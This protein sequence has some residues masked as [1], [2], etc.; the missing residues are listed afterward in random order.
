VTD[1]PADRRLLIIFNPAAGLRRRQR[2]EAVLQRLRAR[3]CAATVCETTGPGDA[4]RFAAAADPTRYDLLVVA[5]GDGTVNEAINGLGDAPLPLAILPLGTANVLAAE[6]GLATDPDSIAAAIAQGAPRPIALG[7][8][9]GRRFILMAGAGFDAHVVATVAT[10]VKRW[11]GKGAYVLAI[12]RQLLA[13]GFPTYQV[14]IDG[15]VRRA[16]SVLIANAHFYGGRFVV[17]PKADLLS[18]TFEVCLFERSGRLAAIG[19]ALALLSGMLPRLASY[20]IIAAARIQI[21]GVPGEPVQG[22]GDII[23]T[24]P[25]RIEVLPDALRLIYPPASAQPR[26]PCVSGAGRRS[27]SPEEPR[28]DAGLDV[29]SEGRRRPSLI[30]PAVGCLARRN[31]R[32]QRNSLRPGAFDHQASGRRA[33]R[34]EPAEIAPWR[35]DARAGCHDEIPPEAARPTC[36]VCGK[37]KSRSEL[38]PAAVIRP[39]L[40]ERIRGA[41]PAWSD[42]GYICV[43]DLNR[44]RGEYVETLLQEEKG[45]LSSLERSVIES[46]ARHETLAEDVEARFK[47]KLSVGERLADQIADF[48]G[49]WT[50]MSL[51]AGFILVWIVIST[52]VLLARSFDPY[53][54]ILLN[55]MLSCLA[56]VQAPVIMMSQNRQ[57]RRKGMAGLLKKAAAYDPLL[58]DVVAGGKGLSRCWVARNAGSQSSSSPER[59]AS[60]FPTITSWSGSIASSILAGCTRRWPNSTIPMVAGRASIRRWRS[61]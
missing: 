56:A 28:S 22:D 47:N 49:S 46:L 51:F 57:E 10:P 42:E 7:A 1:Q 14:A 26:A 31:D 52:T 3:G 54:F 50:F 36:Q 19:Y 18:P 20:R 38:I 24:L 45:E 58:P 17:A 37:A 34:Q 21:D 53:P 35:D 4:E 61:A 59:F 60:F 6:I 25:A 32:G 44:F 13:Y 12:L 43:A 29:S 8:A 55:L 48:G 39:R 30:L 5:G 41:F 2:L 15:T 16:G 9:N 33:G 23:A 40:A 27:S 11:L